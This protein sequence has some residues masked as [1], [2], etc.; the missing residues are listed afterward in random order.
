L[1][2]P[3]NGSATNASSIT[4]TYNVQNAIGGNPSNCTL[5]GTLSDTSFAPTTG[6]NTFVKSPPEGILNWN[7]SCADSAGTGTSQTWI[8]TVDRNAPT[9]SLNGPANASNITT[10]NATFNWTIVDTVDSLLSCT[11]LLDNSSFAVVNATNGTATTYDTSNISQGTHNWSVRCGDDAGNQNTSSTLQFTFDSLSPN[12]TSTSIAS[13]VK[14]GSNLTV[15]YTYNEARAA[16]ITIY[17][18]NQSNAII[19]STTITNASS[20]STVTRSDTLLVPSNATEGK[21][22]IN[23]TIFD[24]NDVPG[25]ILVQN[26]TAVDNTAP[27]ISSFTLSATSVSVGTTITGSCS[28]TDNL[29]TNVTTTITGIDTASSGSKTAVCTATDDAGNTA[30]SSVSYT[31]SPANQSSTQSSTSSGDQQNIA[32][33][34]YTGYYLNLQANV[35]KA[36]TI[37]TAAAEK[38]GLISVEITPTKAINYVQLDFTGIDSKPNWISQA[39]I[40]TVY[41]YIGI[42]KLGIGDNDIS[43]IKF[44]FQVDKSWITQK[45]LDPGK[46]SLLRYANNQWNILATTKTGETASKYEYEA[47]SPGLSVF[48]IVGTASA[49]SSNETANPANQTNTTANQTDANIAQILDQFG[50]AT[51]IVN[52]SFPSTQLNHAFTAPQ[53]PIEWVVAIALA[54]VVAVIVV[55]FIIYRLRKAK[56]LGGYSGFKGRK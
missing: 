28:A 38:T 48:A 44:K 49:S 24:I 14:S 12:I 50:N 5:G 25:S 43:Q 29:D 52:I 17:L 9:I 46:I 4:F 18:I 22:H 39:P 33:S 7:V 53:T 21:Y 26:A 31:V 20:G 13:G 2:T 19:N 40:G 11:I 47:I 56:L 30:T 16:N 34:D 1:V 41:K 3:A 55:L 36:V 6:N 35:G 23:I 42:D 54:S 45:S 37:G 8:L 15:N 27:T 10:A 32:T 51:G